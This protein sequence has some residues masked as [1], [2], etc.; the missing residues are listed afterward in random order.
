[1]TAVK[2][3]GYGHGAKVCAETFL[4]NGADMLA[5]ATPDEGFQLRE[6]GIDAPILCL[7]YT[8]DYLHGKAIEEDVTTTIYSH[9]QGLHL[10]KTAQELNTVARF[11]VKI[12]TGMSRLG[13]QP[14]GETVESI[15][16]STRQDLRPGDVYVHTRLLLEKLDSPSLVLAFAA[17]FHDVGKPR[18]Y[19]LRD[20]RIRFYEHAPIGADMTRDIM[21][22]LRFSNE[23][24]DQVS[25]CVENH[26][27][28]ADVQKMRSGKLKRF[29]SRPTFD[30][31]MELHMIDC[32]SSHGMLD[33]YHFLKKKVAEY[34]EE[35]LKPKPFINGHDLM[36]LGMKAGPA[37]KPLLEELYDRQLEGQ[38]QDREGALACAKKLVSDGQRSA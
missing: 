19:E 23:E 20:G 8:P 5:V 1:M 33:N 27:K 3:D 25:E 13:Y 29:V 28:F 6:W 14:N 18:T 21:K 35:E 38:F 4:A 34:A 22:K 17:L 10:N 16:H 9:G 32:S 26:M 30:E 31:E 24:I 37:M 7:G 15:L 11:H 36:K 2:A 12:D